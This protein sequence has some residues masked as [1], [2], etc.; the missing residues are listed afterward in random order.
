MMLTS[1]HQQM[2]KEILNEWVPGSRTAL[3]G[4]RA[5]GTAKKFSDVDL[6]IYAK[7]PISF[8]QMRQLK[9]AFSESRLPFRVDVVDASEVSKEF[10][11]SIESKSIVIQD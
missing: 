11:S 5:T 10:L 6:L 9:D 4:S 1:K 7:R 2:I 3:F 8:R